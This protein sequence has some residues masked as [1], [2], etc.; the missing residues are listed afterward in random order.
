M[1]FIRRSC[2][3][4]TKPLV[5]GVSGVWRET[6]SACRKMSS[7]C[8]DEGDAHLPRLLRRDVGIEGDHLHVE[9]R[10]RPPGDHRTDP[11]DSHE[12]EG[13]AVEIDGLVAVADLPVAFPRRPVVDRHLLGEGADG[14]QGVLGDRRGVCIRGVDDDDS[15][16]RRRLDID[17]V[18]ADPVPADDLEGVGRL[19]DL[20]REGGGPDDDALHPLI[21]LMT[22]ATDGSEATRTSKRSSNTW[23][24]RS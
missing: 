14:G 10:R 20:P 15:L 8:G 18:H 12:A 6:T 9:G 22:V 13:L 3:A 1:G 23:T 4:L 11:P 7:L 5:S 19:D 24:P 16:F 2:A 21:S 17:I